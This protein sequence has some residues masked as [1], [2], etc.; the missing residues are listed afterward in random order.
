MPT[1]RTGPGQFN[2][3]REIAPGDLDVNGR[4]GESG[5]ALDFLQSYNPVVHGWVLMLFLVAIVTA[6]SPS[7]FY[8]ELSMSRSP[9]ARVM[10]RSARSWLQPSIRP[11]D[12]GLCT[13][14]P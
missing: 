8:V 13:L 5:H 6:T 12:E 1:H 2:L 10:L 7:T 9:F 4:A 14:W 3:F 11:V